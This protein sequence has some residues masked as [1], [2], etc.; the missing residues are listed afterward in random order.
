MLNLWVPT[1][2]KFIK[3]KLMKILEK[4]LA[5]YDRSHMQKKKRIENYKITH[6]NKNG[7]RGQ[8]T[9]LFS[10]IRMNLHIN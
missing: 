5:E 2:D 1:Q 3:N 10:Q 9:K 7:S 6:Y 8:K 4:I